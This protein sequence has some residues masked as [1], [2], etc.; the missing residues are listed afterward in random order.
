VLLLPDTGAIQNFTPTA[1]DYQRL[2]QEILPEQLK[3][4]I[5]QIEA[6]PFV[7][8]SEAAKKVQSAIDNEPSAD[9]EKPA[10]PQSEDSAAPAEN[11]ATTEVADSTTDSLNQSTEA[12]NEVQYTKFKEFFSR[13]CLSVCGCNGAEARRPSNHA[14]YTCNCLLLALLAFNTSS[15]H[16]LCFLSY[17]F[18]GNCLQTVSSHL[19]RH[20]SVDFEYNFMSKT[21]DSNF[22]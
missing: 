4:K 21:V 16:N 13:H 12:N 8:Q 2:V 10:E 19:N 14:L 5:S 3:Q 17:L 18:L 7:P 11:S 15:A 9:D 20:I 6:E 22:S 1:D